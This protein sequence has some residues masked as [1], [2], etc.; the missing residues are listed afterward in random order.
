MKSLRPI[1]PLSALLLASCAA[2]VLVG[3][4]AVAGIWTYDD[5]SQD[6]G[7]II[8]RTSAEEAFAVAKTVTQARTSATQFNIVPGSLRIEFKEDRADVVVQVLLMPST[9]EFT[10]LRVYASE[11][12]LR[13]RSEL[14]R[15]V[16]EDIAAKFN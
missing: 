3:V 5:Y 13:G 1:F 2:P 16:A 6:S 15:T 12:R 10:T 14:A 8:L 9:P 4:G 7:E 11:L